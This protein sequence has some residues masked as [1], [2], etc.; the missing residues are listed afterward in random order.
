M[1]NF[2]LWNVKDAQ[3]L[4]GDLVRA[5]CHLELSMIQTCKMT[6][7]GDSGSLTH[8]MKAIQRQVC[9]SFPSFING[10]NGA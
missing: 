9:Y 3:S 6:A 10:E 8:D 7:E 2:V 1:N 4:E 5:A